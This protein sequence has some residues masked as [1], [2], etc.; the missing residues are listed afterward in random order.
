MNQ[1]EQRFFVLERKRLTAPNV[2]DLEERVLAIDEWNATP[3]LIPPV[4]VRRPN[5]STKSS[6][7]SMTQ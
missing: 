6:P 7:R 1:V 5:P 4:R 2:A 3:K